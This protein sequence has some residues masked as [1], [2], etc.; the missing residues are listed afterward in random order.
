MYQLHTSISVFLLLFLLIAADDRVF[1]FHAQY[2]FLA[3]DGYSRLVPTI[4]GTIP[5][6][7]IEINKNDRLIVYVHNQMLMDNVAVHFHGFNFKNNPWMDGVI[8][9]SQAIVCTY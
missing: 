9:I 7:Q 5:G 6:P 4:N 3:P 1:H 8:G 2:A